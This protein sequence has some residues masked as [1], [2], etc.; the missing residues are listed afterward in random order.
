[1]ADEWYH[2]DGTVCI[3]GWD[4]D[5]G[6]CIEGGGPV[7]HSAAH[8]QL[9]DGHTALE[10]GAAELQDLLVQVW[11]WFN[12]NRAPISNRDAVMAYMPDLTANVARALRTP[13]PAAGQTILDE[14]ERLR[15]HLERT[16]AG[17]HTA[18]YWYDR[19]LQLPNNTEAE[20]IEGC[21][22]ALRMAQRAL[23]QPAPQEPTDG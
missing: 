10:V 1:M 5:T 17:L 23:D 20:E 19:D 13:P 11:D 6:L 12:I 21:R 9:R 4:L 14:I 18:L 2:L 7:I 15:E 3:A 16:K 22:I 8:E